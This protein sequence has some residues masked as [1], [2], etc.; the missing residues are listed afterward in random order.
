MSGGNYCFFGIGGLEDSHWAGTRIRVTKLQGKH[1]AMSRDEGAGD[2][3]ELEPAHTK[4]F[5][6]WIK[7]TKHMLDSLAKGKK[8][9]ILN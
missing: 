4:I 3:Q 6:S 5:I 9:I 7:K 8:K 1:Q 2:Y